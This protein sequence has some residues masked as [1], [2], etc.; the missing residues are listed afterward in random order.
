MII[1][2]AKPEDITAIRTI[3]ET[4]DIAAE[5]VDYES[6]TGIVLVAD[7]QREVIGM[8]AALPGRPVAVITDMA[9]LPEH[10]KG[11]AAGKLI[12]GMRLLLTSLGCTTWAAFINP[13]KTKWCEALDHIGTRAQSTGVLYRGAL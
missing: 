1:R 6:W 8:I 3:L 10:R 5:G 9:V 4:C 12:D 13:E 7:R 2:P 11:R